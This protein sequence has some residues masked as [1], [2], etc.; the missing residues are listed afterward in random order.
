MV[1]LQAFTIEGVRTNAALLLRVLKE[2]DFLQSNIDTG[3]V[4][5]LL[6]K[7]ARIPAL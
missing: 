4:E 6:R 7:G 1:A 5:R 3:M 2:P